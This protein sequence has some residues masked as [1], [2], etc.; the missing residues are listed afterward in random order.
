MGS[1]IV[2]QVHIEAVAIR[3][4]EFADGEDRAAKFDR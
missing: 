1:D 3:L 2:A 4:F